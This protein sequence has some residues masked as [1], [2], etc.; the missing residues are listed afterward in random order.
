MSA[1]EEPL[2]STSLFRITALPQHLRCKTK[3][4]KLPTD[5]KS[6]NLNSTLGH[7]FASADPSL[8]DKC[9]NQECI[10]HPNFG[11]DLQPYNSWSPQAN[12]TF[13]QETR[14]THLSVCTPQAPYWFLRNAPLQT[15]A[16]TSWELWSVWSGA[17]P[18]ASPFIGPF[19]SQTHAFW[20][21]FNR[22]VIGECLSNS[23]QLRVFTISHVLICALLMCK[24]VYH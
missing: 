16:T 10:A 6:I 23:S 17:L 2:L 24:I 1:R 18:A 12:V 11:Y 22:Q 19:I 21:R 3:K 13:L 9:T 8:K 5:S 20:K 14:I 15:W 7:I 4:A